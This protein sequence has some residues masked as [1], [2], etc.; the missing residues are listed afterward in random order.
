[1]I[2]FN[3]FHS[4]QTPYSITRILDSKMINLLDAVNFEPSQPK[5]VYVRT[6]LPNY[7]ASHPRAIRGE[8][9]NCPQCNC[10]CVYVCSTVVL[11]SITVRGYRLILSEHI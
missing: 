10:I 8:L 5:Y 7:M 11:R 3:V 2:A 9:S 6:H 1:M 4:V